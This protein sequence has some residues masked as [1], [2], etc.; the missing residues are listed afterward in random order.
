MANIYRVLHMP[1]RHCSEFATS[2]NS[3]NPEVGIRELGIRFQREQTE[4]RDVTSLPRATQL[5]DL[6]PEWASWAAGCVRLPGAGCTPHACS[7]SSVHAN[8]RG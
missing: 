6:A 5:R 8:V 1:D 3:L 7:V 4:H 2:V